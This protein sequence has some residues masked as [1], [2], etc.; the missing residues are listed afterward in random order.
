MNRAIYLLAPGDQLVE[1]REQ[2]YD[3]EDLL[4][5]L[6]ATHPDLLAG[7]QIDPATPRRWLL[8]SREMPVPADAGLGGR[9]SLDHLFIDQEGVPTLVEVKR[10]T[11]NWRPHWPRK[12]P[13]P[14]SS[15]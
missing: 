9:W 10:S 8:V 13:A 11:D 12:A 4:Q 1:M 14:T 3:S 2:A 5:R 15:R 7:D 6:L